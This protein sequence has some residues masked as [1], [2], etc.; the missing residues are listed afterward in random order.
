MLTNVIAA[1]GRRVGE[2]TAERGQC[3]PAAGAVASL[4]T[5]CVDGV[6][7]GFSESVLSASV[8]RAVG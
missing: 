5:C 3:H 4:A 6:H 8:A 7:N 2:N 1:V